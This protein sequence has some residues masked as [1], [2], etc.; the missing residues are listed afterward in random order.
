MTFSN[1]STYP[2]VSIPNAPMYAQGMPNN[3]PVTTTSRNVVQ[4]AA[5]TP[6]TVRDPI[7]RELCDIDKIIAL[8]EEQEKMK[9]KETLGNSTDVVSIKDVNL[10]P[11]EEKQNSEDVSVVPVKIPEVVSTNIET[12]ELSN[13][14][15]KPEEQKANT[16]QDISV[17]PVKITDEVCTNIETIEVD[18]KS[19]CSD[20]TSLKSV[21]EKPKNENDT[22]LAT[23]TYANIAKLLSKPKIQSN[24]N[25][26]A[27]TTK[28]DNNSVK[29]C[30]YTFLQTDQSKDKK[31]SKNSKIE[32]AKSL[33]KD[34]T[35]EL[36]QNINIDRDGFMT[37]GKKRKTK[38]KV[39]VP[40][41]NDNNHDQRSINYKSIQKD[42]AKNND[43]GWAN[44]KK[45]K[46]GSYK[47]DNCNNDQR[48]NRT[49]GANNDQR[50]N[51]N[52]YGNKNQRNNKNG[53]NF[54]HQR[55]EYGYNNERF[56]N[57][58]AQENVNIDQPNYNENGNA[59]QRPYTDGRNYNG[60]QKKYG[61]NNIQ[62]RNNNNSVRSTYN[63]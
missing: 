57:T 16:E 45:D 23:S 36:Q 52:E 42:N 25:N 32:C 6:L 15:L 21:E 53:N 55:N 41:P 33:V 54:Q 27:I 7:S 10:K 31:L 62:R 12:H 34:S 29:K 30:T 37:V 40:K 56:N 19:E 46:N 4:K 63:I 5:H 49:D 39:N 9:E 22:S 59:T 26:A 44:Y 18:I 17:A 48:L 60:N 51:G 20:A 43:Q 14:N 2:L 61:K 1:Q 3:S 50:R 24:G 28:C 8:S 38:T 13:V 11:V 58:R 47:N 35:K